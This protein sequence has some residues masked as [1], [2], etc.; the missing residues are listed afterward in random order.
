MHDCWK[1][2]FRL[3][4]LPEEPRVLLA[5]PDEERALVDTLR[6]VYPR[7]RIS[8][9]DIAQGTANPTQSLEGDRYA[10]MSPDFGGQLPPAAFDVSLIEHALDDIVVEAVANSEGLAPDDGGGEYAPRSRAVRAYWRCGDLESIARPAFLSIL[11][12]CSRALR[13]EALLILHHQVLNADLIGGMPMDLYTEYVEL[14]RNWIRESS[15]P[16]CEVS[17]DSLD[18]HWWLCLKTALSTSS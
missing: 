16:L 1:E 3:I 11:D 8:A 2:I 9:I 5:A 15:L 6:A 13:P 4:A 12:A 18:S 7:A 17:L 14:A 10:A